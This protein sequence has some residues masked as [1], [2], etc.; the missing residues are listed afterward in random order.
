MADV[1]HYYTLC[2]VEKHGV[3]SSQRN[4]AGQEREALGRCI[5][6]LKYI[7]GGSR[8][9]P[10]KHQVW[11]YTFASQDSVPERNLLE[12]GFS[13]GELLVLSIEGRSAF[14]LY[15]QINGLCRFDIGT[16]DG[17]H[18]RAEVALS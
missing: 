17:F 8:S 6:E 5:S 2:T 13:D 12:L 1:L 15:L 7:H 10:G 4:I 9:G 18:R 16:A 14:S 3:R 11:Y